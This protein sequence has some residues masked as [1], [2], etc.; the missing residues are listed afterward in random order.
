MSNFY[1]EDPKIF[2]LISM[3]PR[4]PLGSNPTNRQ[5]RQ[6]PIEGGRVSTKEMRKG[7]G[8][9]LQVV[10]FSGE[11]SGRGGR[12]SFVR[13]R[14]SSPDSKVPIAVFPHLPN[15]YARPSRSFPLPCRC[16][17]LRWRRACVGVTVRRRNSAHRRPL[18]PIA[19][20]R[21]SVS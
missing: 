8:E 21:F 15:P 7:I 9:R 19:R 12:G 3:N 11:R 16:D 6:T 10:L 2:S 17:Q 1:G 5:G 13:H 14:D 20:L 18:C 4:K